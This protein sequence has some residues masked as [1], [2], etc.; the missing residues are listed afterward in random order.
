MDW[1]SPWGPR[2]GTVCVDLKQISG[3]EIDGCPSGRV[4]STDEAVEIL[5]NVKR[6]AEVLIGPRQ[7]GGKE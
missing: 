5:V 7:E 2:L 6:F 4:V 3:M 1:N